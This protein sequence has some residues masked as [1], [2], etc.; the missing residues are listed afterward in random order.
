MHARLHYRTV[1]I[2]VSLLSKFKLARSC[3]SNENKIITYHRML[4]MSQLQFDFYKRDIRTVTAL[5]A[6]NS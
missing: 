3:V 2:A 6:N 5:A 1:V 4:R